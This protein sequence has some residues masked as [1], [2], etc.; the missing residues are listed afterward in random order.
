MNRKI[1]EFYSIPISRQQCPK[2][3]PIEVYD[4]PKDDRI[5]IEVE[6]FVV[7]QVALNEH[8]ENAKKTRTPV[9]G[10]GIGAPET[11]VDR[12]SRGSTT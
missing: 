10:D 12:L 8:A 2:H 4:L 3:A 7:R 9:C 6:L 5:A 1:R 11:Q